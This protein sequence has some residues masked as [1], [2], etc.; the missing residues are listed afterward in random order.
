MRLVSDLSRS[1]ENSAG[2]GGAASEDRCQNPCSAS[3]PSARASSA[4]SAT[5]GLSAQQ[6]PGPIRTCRPAA[7]RAWPAPRDNPGRPGHDLRRRE[8]HGHGPAPRAH[9]RHRG[10]PAGHLVQRRMRPLV[11]PGAQAQ[12]GKAPEPARCERSLLG[13]HFQEISTASSVIATPSSNLI[14]SLANSPGR[15]PLP[16]PKSKRPRARLSSIAASA[17]RRSG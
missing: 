14:P 15:T 5:I 10:R 2:G 17:A 16:T 3:A 1:S 6:Q 11:D 8:M 13:P 9:P 4:V 7:G 12:L